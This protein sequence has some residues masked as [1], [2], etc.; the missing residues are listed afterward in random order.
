MS[1]A[2]V[3][4]SHDGET[5]VPEIIAIVTVCCVVTSTLVIL[6]IITR[7]WIVRAFGPDDWVLAAAQV[8]TV[9]EAVAI[10]LGTFSPGGDDVVSP[11][12]RDTLVIET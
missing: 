7:A 4:H 10:G 2:P 6:R 1:T 9:A 8:L 5:K 3:D 11:A 12:D